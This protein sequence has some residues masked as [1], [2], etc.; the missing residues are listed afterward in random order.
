MDGNNN[1]Q[2]NVNQNMQQNAN[3]N[4]TQQPGNNFQNNDIKKE[5]QEAKGFFSSFFKDPIGEI[6]KTCANYDKKYLKIAIIIFVVWLVVIFASNILSTASSYLFGPWGS[7]ARFFERFFDNFGD[8]IK[9]LIAPICT[10]AILS[11]LTYGVKKGNKKSFMQ[12]ASSITI[13]KM[14]VVIAEIVSLLTIVNTRIGTFTSAFSGFC[15]IL[16]TVLLF[17]TIKDTLG[18]KENKT[19]FWKF[20]LIIGIY[21]AIK[22]VLTFINI[23]I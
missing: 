15:S 3:N 20:A 7:F 16:S 14:P 9:S 5:A 23:Y 2:N 13:A 8:L 1:E 6:Q 18:E 4:F 22:F 10:I 21:Y 17:F 12:I 19:S 11:A